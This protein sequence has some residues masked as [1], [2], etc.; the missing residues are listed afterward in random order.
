MKRQYLDAGDVLL[1]HAGQVQ[2]FGGAPGLRDP[3]QLD[4]A[5]HRPQSGYYADLVEEAAAL[6]ESL[7]QNHP[8][9]D[10]NKR[11]ALASMHVFLR[12]NGHDLSAS[13][14]ALMS[15]VLELYEAGA[16]RF[17]RLEGWLRE[18]THRA[19]S[20]APVRSDSKP[21][22]R[23]CQRKSPLSVLARFRSVFRCVILSASSRLR[24]R[25][26]ASR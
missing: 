16:F 2:G 20:G 22:C 3:G 9:I 8:F 18:N 19:A 21:V 5:L 15:F 13:P 10:G 11:T 14:E 24:P 6:W 25:S 12:L 7:S 1:L 26:S 23:H 17:E 4:A